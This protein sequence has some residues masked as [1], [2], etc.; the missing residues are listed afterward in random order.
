MQRLAESPIWAD[1][2]TRYPVV[3]FSHGLNGSPLTT[4]YLEAITILASYGYVVIAPFHGDPRF[5]EVALDDLSALVRLLLLGDGVEMQAIRPLTLQAVLDQVLSHPDYAAHVDV[6]RIGGFGTSLGGETLLLF[7]GG[8]LTRNSVSRSSTQ[9]MRDTRL[10][11]AAGY[12]PYFGQNFLPAFGDEQEGLQGMTMPFLAIAGTEDKTAPIGPI[13]DGMNRMT[14]SRYL[15]A[16]E[17]LEHEI[18]PEHLPDIF[19]WTL[20]F[21]DAHLKGDLTTRNRIAGMGSVKGGVTDT[22]RISVTTPA[23]SN[24]WSLVK[25]WNLLGNSLNRTLSVSSLFDK[26]DTVASVWKWDAGQRQWQFHAPSLDAAELSAYATANGFGVLTNLGP[27]EG[28]WVNANVESS[29]NPPA[30]DPFNLNAG[31]LVS[32][33]QLCASG[34]EMTPAGFNLGLGSA[35]PPAGSIPANILSLWAWDNLQSKWYFYA[36]SLDAAGG[37]VLDNF[38]A[39]R[40][41]LSFNTT[42]KTLGVGSGFWVNKP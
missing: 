11:A 10:V 32:G 36:P 8:K 33:W 6:N 42:G 12:I 17:G 23:I 15:V 34:N 4:G 5:A 41:Y 16:F 21:F 7:G 2:S 29:L 28:F 30:T 1:A 39:G 35:P 38:I 18:L 3:L 13:Q 31:G 26:A 14:G 37:N 40:G 25:G 9:V 24:A 27:G 20:A 22:L 19:T